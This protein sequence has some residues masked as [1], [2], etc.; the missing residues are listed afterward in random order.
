MNSLK[1]AKVAKLPSLY[2]KCMAVQYKAK[3]RHTLKIFVLVFSCRLFAC[4]KYNPFAKRHDQN[5]CALLNPEW[6][7]LKYSN[8]M[9]N[10]EV[11]NFC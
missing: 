2:P 8:S 6:I 11:H 5:G 1:G 7:I 10:F 4:F 9:L 3:V